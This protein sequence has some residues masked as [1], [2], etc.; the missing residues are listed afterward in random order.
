MLGDHVLIWLVYTQGEIIDTPPPPPP[1]FWP[2]CIF[3]G[4][5]VGVYILRPH[6]VGI[7]YAPPPFIHPP[8]LEGYF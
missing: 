7:L 4:R 1:H 8:P 2:K 6:A 5:G 3:Q